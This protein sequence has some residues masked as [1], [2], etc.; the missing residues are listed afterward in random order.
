MHYILLHLYKVKMKGDGLPL[1]LDPPP[2]DRCRGR[3]LLER[4]TIY[5][6]SLLLVTHSSYKSPTVLHKLRGESAILLREARAVTVRIRRRQHWQK[7][8]KTNDPP[9]I[10]QVQ[11]CSHMA[12]YKFW[13]SSPTPPFIFVFL[14]F[15][16][17]PRG[18]LSFYVEAEPS[19]K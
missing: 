10:F 19:K 12:A 17:L 13:Q 6:S 9:F 11:T 2:L 5:L 18:Y 7:S 14:A 1:A 8:G 4:T 16:F 15:L 3:A